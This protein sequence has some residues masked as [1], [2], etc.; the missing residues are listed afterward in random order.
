MSDGDYAE[1][2]FAAGP[3][4]VR[5]DDFTLD[6]TGFRLKEA[7]AALDV[8][9]PELW[10]LRLVEPCP[11]FEVEWRH[12]GG[13]SERRFVARFRSERL[14]VEQAVLRLADH[15]T[16]H[17][18]HALE[19]GW[20]AFENVPWERVGRLPE[21]TRG[22]TRGEGAYRQARVSPEERV[23]ATWGPPSAMGAML[24]WLAST[25]ERRW[26]D[27]PKRVVVTERF[28]YAHRRDDTFARLPLE[29]LRLRRGDDDAIYVFGRKTELVLPESR[30]GDARDALDERLRRLSQ[31]G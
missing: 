12:V 18:P 28:V 15:V 16:E 26:R 10:Q 13:R 8:R 17:R 5:P 6:P 9:W 25:P 29:T 11:S 21:E 27:H 1:I 20:S 7:M 24:Q 22:Q 30:R 23:V 2:D 3:Q 4:T 14:E 31:R 19:P